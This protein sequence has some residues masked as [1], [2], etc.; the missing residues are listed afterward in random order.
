MTTQPHATA[1]V[2]TPLSR[3]R[4]LRTA[5][6]L[7]DAGGIDALSMRRL[8]QELGVEAMSLYNHI[9]NKEDLLEAIVDIAVAEIWVPAP[10]DAWKPAMR[11]RAVSEREMLARH[12]WAL[13]LIDASANPSFERLRYPEAVV[14]C[15]RR[16]GFSPAMAIH[17]FA[18]LDS[19][20]Y[21]FAIQARSLPFSSGD[22]LALAADAF[23]DFPADA[24]PHLAEMITELLP[25]GY[26]FEDEFPYGLDL[27][28]DGLERELATTRPRR[29]APPVRR[30]PRPGR[31]GA[32][33]PAP[34]AGGG[35]GR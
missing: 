22:D 17:A 7:A 13:G 19:Y 16:S 21:G 20:V 15:L 6:E 31:R 34:S 9:A 10:D 32:P 2:R 23:A 1:T 25:G 29:K 18:A 12:P 28:L 3:E 33:H 35:R 4:V 24:F 27:L 5:I 30:S 14:A 11:R 26:E 8:A